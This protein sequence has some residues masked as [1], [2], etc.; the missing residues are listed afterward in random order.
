M[1]CIV[2]FSLWTVQSL[3]L[4]ADLWRTSTNKELSNYERCCGIQAALKQVCLT[5]SHPVVRSTLNWVS[6]Q[7]LP[8]FATL[9][10]SDGRET[11][12]EGIAFVRFLFARRRSCQH[13]H[14]TFQETGERFS[15]S[16]GEKAGMRASVTTLFV[17]K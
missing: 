2:T 17:R 9:S 6:L 14:T 5:T 13:R 8:G 12:G 15:F 7:P 4:G 1:V 11:S 10:R 16:L 3:G